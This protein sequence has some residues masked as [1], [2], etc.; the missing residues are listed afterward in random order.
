[1]HTIE[2]F[3][4]SLPS[5][6]TTKHICKENLKILNIDEE[7]QTFFSYKVEF[8]KL[9]FLIG[10]ALSKKILSQKMKINPEEVYFCKNK[11]G[12]LYLDSKIHSLKNSEKFYFNISHTDGL[13]ICIVSK[14]CDVGIDI[15]TIKTMPFEIINDIFTPLQTQYIYSTKSEWEINSRFYE[16]WTRKEAYLKSLGTGIVEGL[17]NL[18]VPFGQKHRW[19]NWEFSTNKLCDTYIFSTA[20]KNN[21]FT[22]YTYVIRQIQFNELILNF[23]N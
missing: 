6:L 5:T 16:I 22:K 23:S 1:M 12:K 8:K 17:N 14:G 10:R 11:F 13:I 20:I 4:T 19:E 15:E 2:I 21:S 18:N 7:I 9:E 3:W